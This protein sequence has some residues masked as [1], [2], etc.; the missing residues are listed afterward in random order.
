MCYIFVIELNLLLFFFIN[1]IIN[2][3]Y[4]LINVINSL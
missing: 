4:F 2:Y 1:L 3:S